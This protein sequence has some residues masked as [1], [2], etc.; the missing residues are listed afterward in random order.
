MRR[1]LL[2]DGGKYKKN[3]MD[4]RF[5]T[6]MVNGKIV[7]KGSGT[8]EYQQIRQ[9]VARLK[10][11][12]ETRK[13][14]EMKR[15]AKKATKKVTKLEA[16]MENMKIILEKQAGF[17][18]IHQSLATKLPRVEGELDT[19]LQDVTNL[20]KRLNVIN[21]QKNLANKQASTDREELAKAVTMC[22]Q[23]RHFRKLYGNMSIEFPKV[24]QERDNA[25]RQVCTRITDI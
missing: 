1:S 7:W 15:A 11:M 23:L 18:R 25:L 16:Q 9:A 8:D 4:L 19:A 20:R 17:R 22:K 10:K 14:K 6:T 5:N 3:C 13:T 24:K 2:S 21:R 12:Q